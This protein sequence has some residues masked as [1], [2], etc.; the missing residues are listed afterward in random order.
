ML[1]FFIIPL[2]NRLKGHP[3]NGESTAKGN[4]LLFSRTVMHARSIGEKQDP[5]KDN[6]V[7]LPEIFSLRPAPKRRLPVEKRIIMPSPT[8][9]SNEL[10]F[11]L[12]S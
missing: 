6:G 10:D 1:V 3:V 11:M 8:R 9:K 5:V 4:H 7:S 12:K 2:L